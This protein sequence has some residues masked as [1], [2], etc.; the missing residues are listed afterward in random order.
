MRVWQKLFAT[1]T[2]RN[3]HKNHVAWIANHG[4]CKTNQQLLQTLANTEDKDIIQGITQILL[5]RGFS[6]KELLQR[7]N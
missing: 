2:E 7:R 5:S 4:I 3:A 1:H 6:R